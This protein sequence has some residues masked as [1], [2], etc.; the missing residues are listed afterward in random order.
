MKQVTHVNMRRKKPKTIGRA[1]ASAN[2]VPCRCCEPEASAEEVAG[3]CIVVELKIKDA[4]TV[5]GREGEGGSW[6][7][8]L[9]ACRTA[10]VHQVSADLVV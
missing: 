10:G 5:K 7:A 9:R 2:E 8:M 1:T 3:G 4:A 6:Q